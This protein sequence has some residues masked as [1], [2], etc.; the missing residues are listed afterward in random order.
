MSNSNQI[1]IILL[2]HYSIYLYLFPLACLWTGIITRKKCHI[3]DKF[4]SVKFN[5][6]KKYSEFPLQVCS[7]NNLILLAKYINTHKNISM[8][9]V[10]YMHAFLKYPL[11]PKVALDFKYNFISSMAIFPSS[12]AMTKMAMMKFEPCQGTS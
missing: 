3:P 6:A 2:L 5:S 11:E 7:I 10:R 8:Q 1:Q 12:E 4:D 9:L